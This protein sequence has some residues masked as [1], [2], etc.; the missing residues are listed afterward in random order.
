MRLRRPAVLAGVAAVCALAPGVATAAPGETLQAYEATITRDDLGALASVGTDMLEVNFDP[1]TDGSKAIELDL[2]DEQAAKLRDE[3]IELTPMDVP[4]FNKLPKAVKMAVAPQAAPPGDSPNPYYLNFRSYSEPGGIADQTR[5]IAQANPDTAKLETIGTTTLGKPIL[6]IKFTDNARSTPDGTR[7][8]AL[9]MAV[10][11]ARE[12][13]TAETA[14]R[15]MQ[16]FGDHSHDPDMAALLK[17]A[18]I[19]FVPVKNPDGYDFTF[20]CGTG[21]ANHMCG[22]GEASSNRL[23]RKTL[24]D[25]TADGIYG[26]SGDGV[27]PNRNYASG[28][29]E[30]EEGA[31]NSRTS[32]TYRGPGALSEPETSAIDALERKIHPQTLINWHSDAELLLYPFGSITDVPADDTTLFMSLVGT[33]G[34]SAVFPYVPEPSG[35]LYTTNGETVEHAY[36]EYGTI[37]FTP[38]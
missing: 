21:A 31:S 36:T 29:N 11:H 8:A 6:A 25:N 12:W 2:Y 18:E 1:A 35:D 3:G 32:E 26:N 10:D 13:I 7:P 19:W 5:A 30:D 15:N 34:D 37:G 20:T 28:W 14:R 23:W 22:A 4:A 17:R 9:F 24:R 27:D 38:E 16:W 33:D